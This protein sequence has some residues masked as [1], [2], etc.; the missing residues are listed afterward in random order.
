MLS[1]RLWVSVVAL[2][3]SVLAPAPHGVRAQPVEV[4]DTYAGDLGSRP[5]LTG[6]WGG[7]RDDLGKR[8]I[9]LDVDLLQ[10]EDTRSAS[11][12]EALLAKERTAHLSKAIGQLG[13]RDQLL[14]ALRFEDGVG[15]E[16]IAATL[17]MPTR[18]HVH[19]RL[20]KVLRSLRDALSRQGVDEV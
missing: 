4:P 20:K 19:R 12:E 9:T 11:P 10:I 16:G 1:R 5:K 18:F 17:G 13:M 7:L 2:S 14:L 15:L 3:L 6:N 8:G